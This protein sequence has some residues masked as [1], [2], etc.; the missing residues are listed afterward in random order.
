MYTNN[1]L[2]E[3]EMKETYNCIKK[4]KTLMNK[5]NQGYEMCTLKTT[6]MKYI[7][8]NTNKWKKIMRS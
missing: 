5:F 8:D 7:E 2:S 6:L 4:N 3:G 1:K